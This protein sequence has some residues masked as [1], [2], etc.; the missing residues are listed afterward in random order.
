ML[1]GP[2]AFSVVAGAVRSY[3]HSMLR[4]SD[5]VRLLVIVSVALPFYSELSAQIT[6]IGAFN[7]A[8][9]SDQQK[10]AAAD[11]Y[12]VALDQNWSADFWFA[13][14]LK[15]TSRDSANSLYPELANSEFIGII[16]LP[17]GMSDYRG[18]A[19][20]AG[21]YT[22]RYQLI[23]QDAN[24]LGVSP[25]PDFLLALPLASD[26]D[27]EQ[28]YA[29]KRLVALSRKTTGSHPAVIALDTA[30]EAETLTKDGQTVIFTV[31]IPSSGG[32]EK[33]GIVIKGSAS[34]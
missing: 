14:E 10:A 18:Q 13:K 34:Q 2:T 20:P 21:T 23:P 24:H 31:A 30:R 26:A 11:G 33:I 9:A 17:E 8:G 25:H 28:S 29:Y 1:A 5:L 15:T 7:A 6:R 27:P 32:K 3:N 19:I 22:L 4:R 12:H 16:K